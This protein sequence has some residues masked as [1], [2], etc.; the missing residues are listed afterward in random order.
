MKLIKLSELV[1]SQE[2]QKTN[3]HKAIGNN[4]Q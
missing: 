4:N 1:K 2:T 3:N